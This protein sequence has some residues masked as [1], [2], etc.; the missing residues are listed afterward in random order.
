MLAL[1]SQK[2]KV[3]RKLKD[4]EA[5]ARS[6]DAA[7]AQLI[8]QNGEQDAKRAALA[9]EL[10]GLRADLGQRTAE[11]EIARNRLNEEIDAR[12]ATQQRLAD[13]NVRLEKQRSEVLRVQE[14]A[15]STPG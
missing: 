8:A 4:A 1:Q 10:D 13:V 12:E 9:A 14:L 3:S 7:L 2:E 6:S 15:A 5:R 11:L